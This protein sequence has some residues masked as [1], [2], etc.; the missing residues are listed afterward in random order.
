MH[1]Y[2]GN[3][4]FNAAR[5]NGMS[6]W[7]SYPYAL[8]GSLMWE[9]FGENEPPALNDLIATSMGGTCLGEV[10]YRISSILLN[11]KSR[12]FRRVLRE[13]GVFILNPVRGV[14][15]L[16]RG[17]SWQVKQKNYLYHDINRFPL[18]FNITV[19]NRYLADDNALFRGEHN[20]YVNFFFEYGD[21]FNDKENKPFDYFVA[22]VTMGFSSNQPRMS[23]V[24]LLGR[25]WTAP[26]VMGKKIET[27]FGVYQHFNYYDSSPVKDGSNITPYLISEAVGVGPGIVY[28]IKNNGNLSRLEQHVYSSLILLGGTKSDYYNQVAPRDYNMGMGYSIKVRTILDFP[29]LVRFS[30]KTDFYHIFT[31]KGYEDKDLTGLNQLHFNV[32]GDRS[33]AALLVVSPMFSF[34]LKDPVSAN[35][36]GSFYHRYTRYKYH[37]NV[38]VGTYEV[39]AGIS[40]KL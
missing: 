32:Q 25:L 28:R 23:G 17:E 19:G 10:T 22:D 6:F 34:K 29:R 26:V 5:S 4:Y 36:S 39:N 38:W 16:V 33:H 24:H 11:D 14:N 9:Y 2:H 27:E 3:T 15:R 40:C 30:L 8:G 1:P 35:L 37:D 21:I 13:A 18:N 20:P 12:G 31:L 7:Q